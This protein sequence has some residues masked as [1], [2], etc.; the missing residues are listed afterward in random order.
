MEIKRRSLKAAPL[1]F[2]VDH[3]GPNSFSNYGTLFA[4]PVVLSFRALK[5]WQ[6]EPVFFWLFRRKKLFLSA[7]SDI[8]MVKLHSGNTKKHA[9]PIFTY[10]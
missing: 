7:N 8:N 9:Y 6:S 5:R 10:N 1:I 4:I 3:L 2:S